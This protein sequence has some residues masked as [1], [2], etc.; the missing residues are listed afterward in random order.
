MSDD[1]KELEQTPGHIGNI[2]DGFQIIIMPSTLQ[3]E[4]VGVLILS[5]KDYT[6]YCK[7]MPNEKDKV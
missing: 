3:R 7:T 4:G 5:P 1:F 2:P 6:L